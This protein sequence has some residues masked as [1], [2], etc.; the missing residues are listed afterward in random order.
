MDVRKEVL[1][2]FYSRF[3]DFNKIQELAI[4][5]VLSGKNTLIVAPTG[6]GKTEAA[7]IPVLSKILDIKEKE[8][9]KGIL[10]IYLTPLRALNRDLL[11]RLYW[12]CE[13]LD[14][15][16]A[17]RHG[18]TTQSERAKQS[19][20]PPE[21]L[22]T[23]PETFQILFLGKRLKEHLKSVRFVIV[24]ELHELL[25]DKRGVQLSLGLERLV[26][27]AGEF[28]R[29]AL[30]A[31][32][33]DLELAGRF[34]FGYRDFDIAYWYDI[35]RY[36]IE[37]LYPKIT[38][39]DLELSKKLG[40]SPKIVW[41]LRV[42][43]E[44]LD[45]HRSVLIFVNTREMA[46]LL[47]S[48]FKKWLPDYPIEIHHSSL[49]REVRERNEKLFKEGKLKAIIATSSLELGIDI[50]YVDAV[51]QYMSPRQVIRAVQRFGRAG[52][53]LE[54]VSKG[55]IITMD[56]DDYAESLVIKRRIEEA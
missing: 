13:N 17:V 29:I 31:T 18:D 53:R 9:V 1:D 8:E 56:P 50:G 47:V 40:W 6:A 35:K 38:E 32:I 45:K 25:D 43:K 11:D 44:I 54:E 3:K 24:D 46:E 15:K 42:I 23:T 12:W 20:K 26:N 7:V 48:R 4:P 33:G 37:V 52:H 49:S 30:S 19:K 55:Y 39:G 10:A 14:I 21:F 27:F 28:Q 2:L 34:I 51:I 5:K 36:D 41:S 16:I 22:I